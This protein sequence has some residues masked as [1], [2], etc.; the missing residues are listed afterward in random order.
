ML[1]CFNE[2]VVKNDRPLG[3]IHF[4]VTM[5]NKGGI[6]PFAPNVFRHKGLEGI[7]ELKIWGD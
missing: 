5:G 3:M 4:T 6:R 2:F 7:G 1:V